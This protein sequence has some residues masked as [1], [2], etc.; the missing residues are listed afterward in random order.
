MAGHEP[1]ELGTMVRI[2]GGE[3]IIQN[4]NLSPD[5]PE[6]DNMHFIDW[7]EL[8]GKDCMKYGLPRYMWIVF[9][10]S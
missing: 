3:P 7:F 4:N 5:Q 9:T 6:G 2:H 8:L 1:L 10:N